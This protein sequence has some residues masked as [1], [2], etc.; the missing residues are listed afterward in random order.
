MHI[1]IEL[2]HPKLRAGFPILLRFF[3]FRRLRFFY[4]L[5]FLLFFGFFSRLFCRRFY[6]VFFRVFC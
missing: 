2:A 4:D 5:F 1:R 6:E 3:R